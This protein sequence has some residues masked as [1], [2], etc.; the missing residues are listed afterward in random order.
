[1]VVSLT[2]KAK[3]SMT[4]NV[5]IINRVVCF[6]ILLAVTITSADSKGQSSKLINEYSV[7]QLTADDG[8]VS[9]E[10]YSIVQD[11]Q[12]LIWFGTAENGVMRYD[13]RKVS[14]F[15]FDSLSE[16]GLSHNDAGNLMLDRNGK[17]WVGTWGGGANLFDPETGQFENFIHN[18]QRNDSISST[19]IQSLFHDQENAIWLGSYDK[20]LNRYIGN[21][22]FERIEK[23]QDK[24][25][26]SHNRI[27]DIEDNDINSLWVATSYGLNLFDKRTQ[28]FTSFFPDNDNDTPT[29]ANEI[30]NILKT[31][32]GKLYVGTQQGP[33]LFDKANGIFTRLKIN[34]G[35]VTD[36]VNSMIEDQEGYIWFVTSKGLYRQSNSN[37]QIEKFQLENNHGLRIVFQ[38]SSKTI[39]VTSETH[40]IYKLV[41]HRKFKSIK[42]SELVAPNGIATDVNGDL[43]IVSSTSQL[44]RWQVLSQRLEKLSEAIFSEKNGFEGS[45]L[46][47]KP[48]V[49]QD[50]NK[51]V[52]VAQDEGLAKFNLNTKQLDLITYPKDD[53]NQKEFRELRA[54]NVDQ[55]GILWIGTYKNGIYQYNPVTKKFVH[56]DDSLGLSHPEVSE[57]FKDNDQNMWVG[58]GDGVNLWNDQ[59][60]R[61]ISFKYDK[62]KPGSLS[63]SIVQDVHQC[64]NGKIWI[65]TQRGLNLYLPESNSFKHF[66]RENGLPTSLIRAVSDDKNG[67][68]WLTTNKGISKLDPYTGQVINY[69]SHNGLIGSNYYPNSL[70][71]GSNETLF[72]SSQRGIEFF[73]TI[74]IESEQSDFN[75]VLTGFNKMGQSFKLDKPYSYITDIQLSYLDYFFSFEFSA[76]DFISP[77]KNQYAYK[78]EGYDDNWID[79]G[80]RN[81]ASFTNLDGGKYTFLVKASNSNG[82][83]S[84]NLLS[85]NL[86][87]SPPPWKTW[88]AY[89]FYLFFVL[90]TVFIFIYLRT[91]FQRAELSRQMD[92]VVALEEQVSEKTASLK[93]QAHDLT[94]ALKK[95]EEATKL[96]SEFLANMSHEIRTPMNG[97][98]GMLG[99]LKGS[100][101]TKEQAHRLSIANSSAN[102]LL[103]LIN[104]ILDF[105]KI[106]AGKLEL[107]FIDFNLRNLIGKLTESLA[108]SA[109][110][111]DI[112]II[113]DLTDIKLSSVK[114]DP[115]RIRQIIMNILSNAIKFTEQGE[116]VIAAKL[117]ATEKENELLF[118]CK[119]QDSG[120]GIPEEKIAS[121][122]SAFSQIDASTTRKYGGTGL[123]LSITKELCNLLNG[124]VKVSSELGNGSCFEISCLVQ[125]SKMS[126]VVKPSIDSLTLSVLIVDDN[127]SNRDALS[128]QL[129]SWGIEVTLAESGDE[130]LLLCDKNDEGSISSTFDIAIIDMNLRKM[131]G[132]ELVKSIRD[133]EHCNSMKLVM[134]TSM[135]EQ[136]NAQHY[137]EIGADALLTKPMTTKDIFNALAVINNDRSS[138]PIEPKAEHQTSIKTRLVD[139]N[140]QWPEET[141]I[142]L[143]EDNRVNQMVALSVLKNIGLKADIA[144]NGVEALKSI[145]A[146]VLNKPYTIV[147]MD[148]QMPE[149]DGYEATKRIRAGEA[150]SVN[151]SIPII[152]MTAN[153]MQGD[154]EKCLNAGMDDYLTKPIEPNS[155]LEKLKHWIN[156]K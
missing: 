134:M 53:I 118:S 123:G 30:R 41:P 100:G 33:F 146:A 99:L 127:K 130:A 121:L 138:L 111:K 48:I 137:S 7:E 27:W 98:L 70:V 20:G 9:S 60:K 32:K 116:I 105:S 156:I 35:E 113:L 87:I 54:L 38:D 119:I 129:S 44:Y 78:L 147:I 104:D 3:K 109:Q 142:L 110:K 149:M 97:V 90:I 112:E 45:R 128:R 49:F 133:I 84:D 132:K 16:N 154:K 77:N 96:K 12:G 42:S 62:E 37:A 86:T 58:T 25:S 31:S 18:P 81:V 126:P 71:K 24:N 39:W 82:K 57:I 143:V 8:F 34:Q 115:N 117:E 6:F 43:L 141:R 11:R 85:I 28:S 15:E 75:I 152:A 74:S 120:I 19:R 46:L 47:E 59:T 92:F 36:Q 23:G 151:I 135:N 61:F 63:G 14:L 125:K 91:R 131:N 68:L 103:I 114:S 64:R 140:E 22:T 139:E 144:V 93:A 145:E 72:T 2:Y 52:W 67:H 50:K 153:A 79:I 80:N 122:F 155:V 55:Y 94:E 65:A 83:W 136:E 66:D 150:G 17:I 124:N 5:L 51:N 29:G 148:C 95:A 89:S 13:G 4:N 73:N 40:G 106:E 10:I 69:D 101:L 102:S 107:E 21:N 76:L 108:L 1:M 56:M 26:L 88:W